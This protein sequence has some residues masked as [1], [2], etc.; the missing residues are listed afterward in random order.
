MGCFLLC[1]LLRRV[2]VALHQDFLE[3]SRDLG[4]LGIAEAWPLKLFFHSEQNRS[5]E[6]LAVGDSMSNERKHF[7][8]SEG[9]G[10]EREA[11]LQE[12]SGGLPQP[13]RLGGLGSLMSGQR[14]PP[15]S[16]Q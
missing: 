15:V 11:I 14:D 2:S 4:A 9:L 3:E 12:F 16:G 7:S 13:H 5:H 1:A 8:R 10:I 6:Q